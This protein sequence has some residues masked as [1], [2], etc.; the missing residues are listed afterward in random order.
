MRRIIDANCN[1][2]VS[3]YGFEQSPAALLKSM[4]KHGIDMAVVVPFTPGDFNYER[5][6]NHV[7]TV[8]KKKRDRLIGF[9]RVD[10]RHG[11]KAV[12]EVNRAAVKLKLQGLK[13]DPFEQAFSI[14]SEFLDPIMERCSRLGLPVLVESGYPALSLPVQVGELADRHPN[15]KILMAHGGQL[16]VSG[17]GIPDALD[18]VKDSPNVY[19][20]SSGIPE[21]GTEC[22][23]ERIVRSVG[24]KRVIFG[25]NSPMNCPAVEIS[26]I[27]A[28]NISDSEKDAIFAGS[29]G[30]LIEVE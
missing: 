16:G 2:G 17:L 20:E 26:R 30:Q 4:N 8:V 29:I 27:L 6:N 25:T 24:A 22:L 11:K 14:T 18:V 15:T 12:R 19:V 5:A 7:A 23:V 1:V 10:P 9:A 21:T 3:V 13:L 28:V